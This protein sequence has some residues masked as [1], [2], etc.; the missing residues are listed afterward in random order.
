M[1]QEEVLSIY[2][3]ITPC[4]YFPEFFFVAEITFYDIQIIITKSSQIR[5]TKNIFP[6]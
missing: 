4:N 5:N 2:N 1:T 3:N 6:V